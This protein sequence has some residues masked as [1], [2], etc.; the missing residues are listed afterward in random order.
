ML[1]VDRIDRVL[2]Q[3]TEHP[4]THDQSSTQMGLDSGL[5]RDIGGWAMFFAYKD[6]HPYCDPDVFVLDDSFPEPVPGAAEALGI[7]ENEA[8]EIYSE[9]DEGEAIELLQNILCRYDQV[10]HDQRNCANAMVKYGT[11]RKCAVC[12][13]IE[14]G[15]APTEDVKDTPSTPDPAQAE[16]QKIA[17]RLF[18]R[19]RNE[20]DSKKALWMF[21][22]ALKIERG[23]D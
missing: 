13:T 7:T 11:G 5:T 21:E 1:N 6:K 15:S 4:E 8:Q 16:R 22:L 23:E 14:Y 12:G 3:V 19:A 20:M 18:T 2:A 9:E 10:P 17:D